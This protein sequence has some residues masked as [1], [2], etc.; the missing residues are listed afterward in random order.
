MSRARIDQRRGAERAHVRV[1]ATVFL[2]GNHRSYSTGSLQHFSKLFVKEPS[3][4]REVLDW[5]ISCCMSMSRYRSATSS[6][7]N[8]REHITHHLEDVLLETMKKRSAVTR[9]IRHGLDFHGELFSRRTHLDR[10]A[11]CRVNSVGATQSLM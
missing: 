7:V 11:G 3:L 4:I 1:P 10:R 8:G 6:E 2:R 9:C 5:L